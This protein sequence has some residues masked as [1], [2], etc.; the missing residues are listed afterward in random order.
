MFSTGTE[1]DPVAMYKIYREKRPKNMMT[2]DTPFYLEINY[3]RKDS[4]KEIWFKAAP[5]GVLPCQLF[6]PG[7]ASLKPPKKKWKRIRIEKSDSD[8]TLQPISQYFVLAAMLHF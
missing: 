6:K 2:N 3:M 7:H 1:R 5:V 4:S 8:K